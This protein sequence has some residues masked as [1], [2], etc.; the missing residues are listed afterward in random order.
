M[1]DS[2]LEPNPVGPREITLMLAGVPKSLAFNLWGRVCGGYQESWISSYEG[3]DPFN[4][5]ILAFVF[6]LLDLGFLS[7]CIVDVI[8][9]GMT[10]NHAMFF[11]GSTAT[12]KDGT[13]NSNGSDFTVKAGLAQRLKG[14]AIMDVVNV[15]QV[16]SCTCQI[17]ITC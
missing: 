11:H 6:P 4:S 16:Y 3:H 5:P 2:D 17:A 10:L 12:A 14:G 8:S 7:S 15:E 13:S 1:V 9:T